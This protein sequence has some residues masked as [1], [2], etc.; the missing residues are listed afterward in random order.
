[1]LKD[2][3]NGFG[4]ISILLHWV[5]AILIIFLFGLGLYMVGLG[6]Y[7]PYYH[8]GPEL[9][10]S[11]GLLLLLLTLFR[12]LW[13]LANGRN[14]RPLPDHSRFIKLV[15]GTVQYSLYLL[16]LIVIG[17]GYLIT[18]AKGDPASMFEWVQL[19]ALIQLDSE[20]V[21]LAGALHYWLAWAIIGLSALHT[22]AALMH[23][24][25]FRD[26]TM[27]RMLNPRKS[28]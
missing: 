4:L 2:H 18:T 1:M 6:Y 15:S 28:D 14:P 11:L 13:R 3:K 21:D 9:H 23:H 27:V 25:L 20:G 5:S 7:D 8:T 19:P 12:I 24:F 16:V 22:A 10:V 26:R 17:S